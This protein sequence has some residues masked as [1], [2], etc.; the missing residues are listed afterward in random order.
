MLRGAEIVSLDSDA[1]LSG[2]NQMLAGVILFLTGWKLFKKILSAITTWKERKSGSTHFPCAQVKCTVGHIRPGGCLVH[3]RTFFS[4]SLSFS[5]TV[6]YC[7]ATVQAVSKYRN[8]AS[9]SKSP[10]P[11]C[12]SPCKRQSY[13]SSTTGGIS[14]ANDVSIPKLTT[15]LHAYNIIYRDSHLQEAS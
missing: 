14:S 1:F 15:L 2:R 5:T 4:L 13:V 7:Y 6:D 3:Q 8:T 10:C 12:I 11:S 9:S